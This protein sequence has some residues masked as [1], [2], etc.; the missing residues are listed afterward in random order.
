[1]THVSA[2]GEEQQL[3]VLVVIDTQENIPKI[4]KLI[5]DVYAKGEIICLYSHK[6]F[7][8]E[9]KSRSGLPRD[10]FESLHHIVC[11]DWNYLKNFLEHRLPSS[12]SV[13]S[14]NKLRI[15]WNPG[16]DGI[17]VSNKTFN[18]YRTRGIDILP[19]NRSKQLQSSGADFLEM[20]T[21]WEDYMEKE[22][23]KFVK[24]QIVDDII[25]KI[26]SVEHN[27]SQGVETIHLD[28][29]P[30]SGATTA[31]NS[32]IWALKSEMRCLTIDWLKVSRKKNKS[33]ESI[34]KD[35]A[36][37]II[38]W[39]NYR[40]RK[41]A[42]L[43]ENITK[44][45]VFFDNCESDCDTS[46]LA[47]LKGSFDRRELHSN[48]PQ[49]ILL[50]THRQN[51]LKL[52]KSSTLKLRQV[53]SHAER[54]TF[55]AKVKYQ[56]SIRVQKMFDFV[57]NTSHSNQ[58]E[59]YTERYLDHTL[60]GVTEDRRLVKLLRFLCCLKIYSNSGLSN[61][62]CCQ[63]L[64]ESSLNPRIRLLAQ[65]NLG[66]IKI[67]SELLSQHI[68]ARVKE[69]MTRTELIEELIDNILLKEDEVD[70][71]TLIQLL[72]RKKYF[73]S[74]DLDTTDTFSKLITDLVTI[75]W[76]EAFRFLKSVYDKTSPKAQQVRA[77]IDRELALLCLKGGDIDEGLNR[78]ERN[79]KKEEN[80]GASLKISSQHVLVLLKWTQ[81]R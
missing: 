80:L 76:S 39:R 20:E 11:S 75:H 24:R 5:L 8:E 25:S 79:L 78:I 65:E 2:L 19:M 33:R 27:S 52:S 42:L 29:E 13:N 35:L 74:L 9:L 4:S 14:R 69:S 30:G 67:S 36:E 68:L 28:H 46:L 10:A 7:R 34:I 45:L 64:E 57:T 66:C 63:Y 58:T 62:M 73:Y 6:K 12:C 59:A 77:Y 48:R 1:M 72:C 32:V 31:A 23:D 44:V 40:Y 17:D 41:E 54:E 43:M 71:D 49:I 21:R 70:G 81:C 60:S 37:H 51:D 22:N 18:F 47:Q 56:P 61:N 16:C 26:R 55:A 53:L 50:C 15:P 3:V 38:N